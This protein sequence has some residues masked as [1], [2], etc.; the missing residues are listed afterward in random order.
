MKVRLLDS[1][2]FSTA[3]GAALS[4]RSKTLVFPEQVVTW[5]GAEKLAKSVFASGH[6]TLFQHAGIVF[7]LEGVSR[8]VVWQ[9][10]HQ[11]PYYNTSQQSQ[12]S[13]S[14]ADV[15]FVTLPMTP[16]VRRTYTSCLVA[17]LDAYEQL[18]E[19]LTPVAEVECKKRFAKKD[20]TALAQRLAMEVARYVL[21]LATKTNLYYTINLLTLMRLHYLCRRPGLP[22]EQEQIMFAMVDA[23]LNAEPELGVF[24][25]EPLPTGQSLEWGSFCGRDHSG[26]SANF[27]G[28]LSG[29]TSRLVEYQQHTAESLLGSAACDVLGISTTGQDATEFVQLLLDPAK[30]RYLA[31]TLSLATVSSLMS[32]LEHVR[33]SFFTR[34]SHTADSQNQRHRVVSGSRPVLSE[35]FSLESDYITPRLIRACPEALEV[36]DR[37]MA[38]TW[39]K[40]NVLLGFGGRR[41]VASYLLP[42][43]VAIRITESGTLGG[44]LH[45]FRSRLCFN[46]QREIWQIAM[47]QVAQIKRAHPRIGKW[48]LPPCAVR[49]RA[50]VK[51]YCPEGP[52]F[53]GVKVWKIPMEDWRRLI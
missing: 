34:L 50:G 48:L 41:E 30:N 36:Y 15:G 21:P 29:R 9:F 39:E 2:A 10:L 37:I 52:R 32:V 14:M 19:L 40:I 1:S 17:Q 16:W 47:E 22:W 18:V 7:T 35:T 53:C 38:T 31:E 12:R 45:K 3:V 51:P 24:F 23:V 46:T 27:D 20:T 33:Y 28:N 42:N 8:G 44:L 11:V 4:C 49:C 6:H 13:V 25:Q 5:S 26:Y 43:A